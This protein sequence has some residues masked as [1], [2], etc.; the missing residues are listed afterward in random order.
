MDHAWVKLHVD[1][2]RRGL[3]ATQA[4]HPVAH[5]LNRSEPIHMRAKN[6]SLYAFLA[7]DERKAE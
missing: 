3:R 1:I 6:L 5:K 7:V 4:L 2:G